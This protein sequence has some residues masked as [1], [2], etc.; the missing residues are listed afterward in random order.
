MELPVLMFERGRKSVSM[1]NT[2]QPT[3]P[4]A[5][6]VIG[7]NRGKKQACDCN[8]GNSMLHPQEML[9]FSLF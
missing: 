4:T 3:S 6:N 8:I 5:P 2:S 9:N 7:S 1:K